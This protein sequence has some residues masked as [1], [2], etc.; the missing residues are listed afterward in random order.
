ML[1]REAIKTRC[2]G[3]HKGL[4]IVSYAFQPNHRIESEVGPVCTLRMARLVLLR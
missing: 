1:Q 4:P 3:K 2:P